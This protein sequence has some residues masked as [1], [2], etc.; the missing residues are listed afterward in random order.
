MT[1]FLFHKNN[2]KI[3]E[4]NSKVLLIP[5]HHLLIEEQKIKEREDI[6]DDECKMIPQDSKLQPSYTFKEI[7]IGDSG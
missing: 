2:K 3:K 5:I 1:N 4:N 7:V 6:E